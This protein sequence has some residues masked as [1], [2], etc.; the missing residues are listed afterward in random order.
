MLV[1][2]SVRVTCSPNDGERM[3]PRRECAHAPPTQTPP[4]APIVAGCAPPLP[5][6]YS[7]ETVVRVNKI[8]I[9]KSMPG[10]KQAFRRI[11]C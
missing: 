1:C 4:T 3:W 11:K 9:Q 5:G 8:I 6:T 7:Q 10:A 2:V